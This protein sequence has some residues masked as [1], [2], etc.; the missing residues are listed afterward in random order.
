MIL[1]CRRTAYLLTPRA[2]AE[3]FDQ[4]ASGWNGQPGRPGYAH[5]RWMRR[6]VGCFATAPSGG[7]ILDFGSGA[8]WCGIEAALRAPT[9]HLA[10]FDPS[11]AMVRIA[12][13]NAAAEGITG[14]EGRVGFG[15][16]PPFPGPG[17]EPYDLVIS[18]GVVSFARDIEAWMAGLARTVRPGGTLVI[19]DLNPASRGMRGRRRSRP[20]LPIRELNA[21]TS[22]EV[23]AWLE[24]RGFR[25]EETAG[26]QL[27]Y[28][29]PQAMHFSDTRLGGALSRP[30]LW[31]NAGLTALDRTLNGRL[32]DQF[33]SWVM[34]FAAPS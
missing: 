33:D 5:F 26:Y 30:I 22:G 16:D 3:K 29:V 2:T 19:G 6:L 13:D 15:E 31:A 12:A 11:P 24:E 4:N 27:T 34:R 7:R 28:P 14:F 18:S 8:G 20:L 25:H 21:H 17:E 1:V 32:V 9:P 23:R 10:A